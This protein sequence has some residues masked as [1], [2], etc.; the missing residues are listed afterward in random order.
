MENILNLIKDRTEGELF[1]GVV[2]ATRVGKS[3]FIRKFIELKVLPFVSDGDLKDKI[4]DEMPQSGSGKIITT[5]EPKFIPSQKTE[6]TLNDDSLLSIRLVDCVGFLI[7]G[8]QG[9]YLEDGPRMVKTPWFLEEIPFTEAASIGT[10]KVITNHSN[11]GILI[12][13]D[14]TINEFKRKDFVDVEEMC[15]KR[16]IVLKK[17][18][19]VVINSTEPNG[20][21]AEEKDRVKHNKVK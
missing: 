2:G 16:L 8:A 5:V 13:T 4:L 10:D 3:T 1:C 18:F 20:K 15:I 21:R 9:A 6:I 19:V 14:G 17:P 11:I 12:T 7:D